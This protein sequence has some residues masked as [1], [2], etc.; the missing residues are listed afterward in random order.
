MPDSPRSERTPRLAARLIELTLR[1]FPDE[2]LSR[3]EESMMDAF[4]SGYAAQRGGRWS[5]FGFIARS[6][7]SLAVAGVRERIS[8]T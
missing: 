6:W 7:F 1:L 4:E 8:P 2:F 5:A 3:F